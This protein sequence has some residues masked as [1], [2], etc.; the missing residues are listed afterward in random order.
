MHN[1]NLSVEICK[2]VVEKEI[3]A[4]NE[5]KTRHM[6]LLVPVRRRRATWTCLFR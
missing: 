5:A 1:A 2:K 6:D 4:V 3:I